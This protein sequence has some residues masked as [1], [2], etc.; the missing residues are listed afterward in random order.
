MTIFSKF[1]WGSLAT[2]GV[3][4]KHHHK[5]DVKVM[6]LRKEMNEAG[7][8]GSA[9]DVQGEWQKHVSRVKTKSL[10]KINKMTHDELV[11]L[12]A[13]KMD[14]QSREAIMKAASK[15]GKS[16]A[17]EGGSSAKEGSEDKKKE[18]R[19]FLK[20]MMSLNELFLNVE[21]ARTSTTTICGNDLK[22]MNKHLTNIWTSYQQ[23]GVDVENALSSKS[24][25]E[26]E[27]GDATTELLDAQGELATIVGENKAEAQRMLDEKAKIQAN[28]D[29]WT[30]IMGKLDEKCPTPVV[31]PPEVKVDFLQLSK[32]VSAPEPQTAKGGGGKK[33]EAEG[34]NAAEEPKE[35]AKGQKKQ[36]STASFLQEGNEPGSAGGKAGKKK[37]AGKSAKEPQGS[38]PQSFLQAPK[39]P[40]KESE[41]KPKTPPKGSEPK[42]GAGEATSFLQEML[43]KGDNETAAADCTARMHP[44]MVMASV[45][46]S[47]SVQ[48][49]AELKLKGGA[50][51]LFHDYIGRKPEVVASK[52]AFLQKRQPAEQN[53]SEEGF[54]IDVPTEPNTNGDD[55]FPPGQFG[56]GIC[57][58][59][60]PDCNTAKVIVSQEIACYMSE[61]EDHI[62]AT[63]DVA[64]IHEKEEALQRKVIADLATQQDYWA[65]AMNE[66]Q[67][68]ADVY[69][70]E[71]EIAYTE[72]LTYWEAS[73][74]RRNECYMMLMELSEDYYCAA[75]RLREKFKQ[76]LF[77]EF[78]PVFMSGQNL[79][80]L[81]FR[82]NLLAHWSDCEP[83][84]ELMS[85]ACMYKGSAL[86]S[87]DGTVDESGETACWSLSPKLPVKDGPKQKWRRKTPVV[88]KH[89]SRWLT[90]YLRLVSGWDKEDPDPQVAL[91]C[92]DASRELVT[93]CGMVL[94]PQ[95]CVVKRDEEEGMKRATP[96]GFCSATCGGG[97]VKITHK[98]E[99]PPMYGGEKCG[100]LNEEIPCNDN[101]CNTPCVLEDEMKED[102]L[103]C[104]GSCKA[105]AL[106][107]RQH[108]SYYKAL[109]R[110]VMIEAKGTGE[111]ADELDE[112]RLSWEPCDDDRMMLT[113]GSS[114]GG[115]EG[116]LDCQGD[117]ECVD[118]IDLVIA[119]EC[120]V[121]VTILGC[122]FM[123]SFVENLLQKLPSVV[124]Y[125][126]AVKVA[127]VKYGNGVMVK[128]AEGQLA[129][130]P[131]LDLVGA[132]AA[133]DDF[134]GA[135][136]GGLVSNIGKSGEDSENSLRAVVLRDAKNTW[137]E[138]PAP[139]NK[140]QLGYNNIAMAA[141]LA[142]QIL[143]SDATGARSLAQ[144]RMLIL[145]KG[146]RSSC[147]PFWH[148][149]AAA[150]KN[151]IVVDVILFAKDA[152]T[153]KDGALFAD[154]YSGLAKGV[155]IPAELHLNVVY[156]LAKMN[157]AAVRGDVVSRV[158]P[159]ICQETES[160]VLAYEVECAAQVR[161]LHKNK[162][163]PDWDLSL[164]TDE[165]FS[166]HDV[167]LKACAERAKSQGYEGFV[168][169]DPC[170][171]S[172][173]PNCLVYNP[174]YGMLNETAGSSAGSEAGSAQLVSVARRGEGE[175][176]TQQ[177]ADP[178]HKNPGKRPQQAD[179]LPVD[180]TC[181]YESTIQAPGW[182][183]L[184][185]GDPNS[186]ETSHYAV[187]GAACSR[188][189]RALDAWKTQRY[190]RDAT[191]I[192]TD[193]EFLK[194]PK[195]W[196]G[197][198]D[199]AGKL[200]PNPAQEKGEGEEKK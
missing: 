20:G 112:S 88:Q 102:A 118:K 4:P 183:R 59:K 30:F 195:Q 137:N 85:S 199:Q 42:S 138:E 182:K 103:G 106:N 178:N 24:R 23:M 40:P 121:S 57:G 72:M 130:A 53:P 18:R 90:Y 147:S 187:L 165:H 126:F 65:N 133:L 33:K 184:P 155:T 132:Y 123:A 99:S 41:P 100:R 156:G 82:S 10:D 198:V 51:E 173:E 25:A 116:G 54:K 128:D 174:N 170:D 157:D 122:W 28:I 154:Q 167:T 111:C 109:K 98:M 70:P 63:D 76:W 87:A 74:E 177:E 84:E 117:E 124:A 45:F 196:L 160:P 78:F 2:A 27:S 168:W 131:A 151:G 34:S 9:A 14:L 171:G 92:P 113:T 163:C 44:G 12:L 200:V 46:G 185:A 83:A 150:K 50:L 79:R 169:R 47:K 49:E 181:T 105:M 60:E 152:F 75:K 69:M 146:K 77:E 86:R 192:S 166:P 96:D 94:C 134:N 119:Y 114:A 120:S 5:R 8:G 140:W 61:I 129:R 101:L 143:G 145:T 39:T 189:A 188:D 37:P 190:Q 108:H 29:V 1:V 176:E 180:S 15:I 66:Y 17:S 16:K 91:Q 64:Q 175:E 141:T 80:T 73:K 7:L 58:D 32:D 36:G 144:K 193:E 139:T 164:F 43:K 93:D 48:Q 135:Q 127:L 35:P 161:M 56:G 38:S 55:S 197:V 194:N 110:D 67:L 62:Q 162:H 11:S 148:R 186:C 89:Q 142:T 52:Y 136:F 13:D 179:G 95:D 3:V 115:A 125:D 97:F 149:T 191:V 31:E 153:E 21:Q 19:M 6:G 26:V 159:R 104:L 172:L 71:R 81:A 158:V 68:E 22:M 107:E